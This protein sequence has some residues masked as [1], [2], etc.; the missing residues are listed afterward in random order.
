MIERYFNL[1]IDNPNSNGHVLKVNMAEGI[2][3]RL[4]NKTGSEQQ[5]SL[6][7]MIKEQFTIF[8]LKEDL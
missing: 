3:K 4:E 8:R 2:E 1:K 7:I 5:D 6:K